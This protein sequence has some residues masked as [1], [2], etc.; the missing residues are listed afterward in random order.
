MNHPAIT[1]LHI[2]AVKMKKKTIPCQCS[3]YL[4][5]T[6]FFILKKVSLHD[7]IICREPL[8][9]LWLVCH[10]GF[11]SLRHFIRET[12]VHDSCFGQERR[13]FDLPVFMLLV[14]DEYGGK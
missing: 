2:K 8:I 12:R 7:G 1:R 14:P 5:S 3:A 6:A 10:E 11:Q 9:V 13:R 4:R